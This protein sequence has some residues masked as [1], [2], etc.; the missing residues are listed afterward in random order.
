MKPFVALTS[1]LLLAVP[2][3]IAREQTMLARVTVYWAKG[4]IGFD[5]HTRQHKTS[6]GTRLRPGHC[7]VDPRRIPYGSHVAFPDGRRCV[8]VDTGTAVKNR[9]AARLL[10]R[11]ARERSALVIDHFF[12]TKE[13]A[14]AWERSHPPFMMVRV[15]APERARAQQRLTAK[16]YPRVE[17][18]ARR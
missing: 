6:T 18:A 16:K 2:A 10:G 4:G 13:Q 15:I 1:L 3:A 12:E 7:A 14:C 9:K 8:A 17:L 11:S 5:R